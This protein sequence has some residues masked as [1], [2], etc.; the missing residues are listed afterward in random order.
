[1]DEADPGVFISNDILDEELK[2]R[3]L[4]CNII[5]YK[6]EIVFDFF[7]LAKELKKNH[8]LIDKKLRNELD[9]KGECT[10]KEENED[11]EHPLIS[12]QYI[13]KLDEEE[14]NKF[15]MLYKIYGNGS[16]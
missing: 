13:Y 14:Y 15:Y 8:N 3:S 11:E 6:E 16:Y 4:M 12:T 9:L 7:G 1:M 2:D 10:I 5:L